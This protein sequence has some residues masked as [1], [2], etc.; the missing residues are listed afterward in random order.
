ML[1]NMYEKCLGIFFLYSFSDIF[2]GLKFINFEKNF[3]LFNI[4]KERKILIEK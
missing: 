1:P 2:F 3:F 4:N